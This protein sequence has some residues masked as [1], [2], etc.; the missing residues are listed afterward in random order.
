MRI[1]VA[2]TCQPFAP[3][4]NQAA[5]KLAEQ[6]SWARCAEEFETAYAETSAGSR[7]EQ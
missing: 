5:G 3:S 2:T 1:F 4:E 6:R 7:I